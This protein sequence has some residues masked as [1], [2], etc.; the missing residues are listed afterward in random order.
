MAYTVEQIK[1]LIVFGREHGI[2]SLQ[3]EGL[4]VVYGP[5]RIVLPSPDEVPPDPTD[6]DDLRRFSV[7]GRKALSIKAAT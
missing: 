7:I 1:D 6:I 5:G 4:A 2:Q 3:L